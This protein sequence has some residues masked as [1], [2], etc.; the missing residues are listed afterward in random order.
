MFFFLSSY[1]FFVFL[2]I[3]DISAGVLCFS[4]CS[5]SKMAKN[6]LR[7]K[8][9]ERK[10]RDNAVKLSLW[11]RNQ[12]FIFITHSNTCCLLSVTG[13]ESCYILFLL[14]SEFNRITHGFYNIFHCISLHKNQ[15]SYFIS[16]I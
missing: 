4:S 2:L 16:F 6:V 10:R 1:N 5:D 12:L 8:K 14:L 13:D 15:L 7:C 11:V 9:E 3:S